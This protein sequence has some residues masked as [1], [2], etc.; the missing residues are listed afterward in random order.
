[1]TA[2]L[3]AEQIEV[4]LPDLKSR[5]RL[6]AQKPTLR[7]FEGIEGLKTVYTET[8]KEKQMIYALVSP[9]EPAE[10]IFRW[11]TTSYVQA[12]VKGNIHVRVVVNGTSRAQEYI[13]KSKEELR[14]ARFVHSETYPFRGEVDVFGDNIAFIAYKE[15]ELIGTILESPSIAETLRSTIRLLM[16]IL[17]KTE[18]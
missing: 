14:E 17:P 15:D 12:R 6:F 9:D 18:E 11:L 7:F 1:M 4:F 8:L 2:Q 16:D 3:L 13:K 5:Y 10:P